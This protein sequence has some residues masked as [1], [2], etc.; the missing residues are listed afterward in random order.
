MSAFKDFFARY[1]Y[2]S[3]KMLLNQIVIAMFG[4]S[5]TMGVSVAWDVRSSMMLIAGAMGGLFYLFLLYGVAWRMGDID[6]GSITMGNLRFRPLTGLWVCLMANIPNFVVA[7]VALV[8]AMTE[9]HLGS[10]PLIGSLLH[11]AY[12]GF[13]SFDFSTV[14]DVAIQ[15]NGFWWMYFLLPIPSLVV[16]TG[17]YMLGAKGKTLTK[18]NA[19]Q[20]PKSDRPTK[21]EMKEREK[22]NKK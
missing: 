8:L 16:S 17:A 18:L 13:L 6:R 10:I 2:D 15:L 11:G 20:P 4:A 21:A 14:E 12:M 7:V 22:E 9:G 5:V 1:S 3:V 19:Y